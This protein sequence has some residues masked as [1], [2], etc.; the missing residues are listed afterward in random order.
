[1][2]NHLIT[3]YGIN[4]R[5]KFGWVKISSLKSLLNNNNLLVFFEV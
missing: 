2:V 5:K 3:F 4:T 1:M